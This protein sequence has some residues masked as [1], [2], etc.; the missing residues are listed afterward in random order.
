MPFAVHPAVVVAV[1]LLGAAAML[2]WRMRETN[3][4]VS[5]VKI[6]APPLGMS[7]GFSMFVA[8]MFRIPWIWAGAAFAAGAL[9]F[10]I[11]LARTSRLVRRGDDILMERSKA[12][13]WILLA[14]VAV[15][16][17]LRAYLE[18]LITPMQTGALFF[19]L[20]FGMILRWRAAMLVSYLRLRRQE[21]SAGSSRAG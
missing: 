2:A 13:L 4:A 8:P 1:T 19:V 11:P 17:A 14:L 7:T 3:G 10:A 6:V 18:R 15:R 20:A 12:F 9:L 5:L 21:P 16:F